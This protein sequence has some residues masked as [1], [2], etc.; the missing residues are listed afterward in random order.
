MPVEA[1]TG[2]DGQLRYQ[3]QQRD[4]PAATSTPDP[5]KEDLVMLI[6]V[7]YTHLDV[8]KRQEWRKALCKL[9]WLLEAQDSLAGF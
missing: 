6:P 2:Q 9:S 4:M 5:Q 3:G 8:Y 7:S 1:A